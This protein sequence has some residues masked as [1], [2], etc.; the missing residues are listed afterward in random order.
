MHVTD[1]DARN[2]SQLTLKYMEFSLRF[3][4]FPGF[5]FERIFVF[6]PFSTGKKNSGPNTYKLAAANI[7]NYANSETMQNWRSKKERASHSVHFSPNK[8]KLIFDLYWNSQKKVQLHF[9]DFSSL[10][11]FSCFSSF[12]SFTKTDS[13]NMTEI[14]LYLRCWWCSKVTLITKMKRD[15]DCHSHMSKVWP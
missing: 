7:I 8:L 10:Q 4:A 13:D 1:C 12:G 14:I 9:S 15:S 6:A 5:V 3:I 11:W 2:F